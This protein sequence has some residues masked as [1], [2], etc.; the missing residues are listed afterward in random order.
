MATTALA[1]AAPLLMALNMPPSPTLLNELASLGFAGAWLTLLA[2]DLRGM[3]ATAIPVLQ[4]AVGALLLGLLWSL[5]KALPLSIALGIGAPLAAAGLLAQ[6]GARVAQHPDKTTR[7]VEFCWALCVAGLLSAAIGAVQVFAPTW[8]DGDIIARTAVSGRAVGNLRQP[9]HLSTLA[10]WSMVLLVGLHGLGALRA[11]WAVAAGGLCLFA[12]VQSAS[13]T[14]IVGVVLLMAW[15]ALDRR[16]SRGERLWLLFAPLAFVALWLTMSVWASGTSH[17]FEGEN[18]LSLEGDV[19]SSR[20]GIWSNAVSMIADEPLA[21]VGFGEF[22]IAWTL[23]ELPGRPTAFFDHTH[24]L[25]LQLLVEL[26]LPLGSL[27]LVLLLLALLQAWRRAWACV[28]SEGLA[29]RTAFVLVAMVGLHSLLEYPL[30]YAYF[31][32]PTAFAWGFALSRPPAEGATPVGGLGAR[33]RGRRA[34]PVGRRS[35]SVDRLPNGLGNLRSAGT[36]HATRRSHRSRPAQPPLRPSRRLRRR[37][38]FRSTESAAVAVAG[39]GVQVAHR[40][41]SS[42]CA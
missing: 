26:G 14:G 40:T 27:V 6:A 4:W 25:P 11:T 2:R 19:S 24:N 10:L 16:L 22:N 5:A 1:F 20:F 28:G 38:R 42:T 33:R 15:G 39:T 17:T 37:D 9:N 23:G 32:L 3:A 7:Y 21:G 31:L 34:D 41:S 35:V 29:R 8:P 18:R 30:W 12:V 13:R 36:R